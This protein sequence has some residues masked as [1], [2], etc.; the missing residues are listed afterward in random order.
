MNSDVLLLVA[1]V[2]AIVF[3]DIAALRFGADS[4]QETWLSPGRDI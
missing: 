4:R 1:A 2:L 3:L